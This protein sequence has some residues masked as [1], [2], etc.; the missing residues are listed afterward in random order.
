MKEETHNGRI[1]FWKFAFCLLICAFHLG[2]LFETTKIRF[3]GGSIAVEFFFLVSGFLFC[4]KMINYDGKNIYEDN[5]KYTWHSIK[6][7]A[8]YIIFLFVISVCFSKFVLNYRLL[9]FLYAF[10]SILLIPAKTPD[11]IHV[12]DIAWYISVLIVVRFALF[13][14]L[15][16]YKKKY[17]LYFAPI[18]AFLLLGYLLIEYEYVVGPWTEDVFT[19]KSVVRGFMEINIGI[20]LYEVCEKFKNIKFNKFS[21]FLLTKIETF[22]YVSIFILCN[23]T[24]PHTKYNALMIMLLF[25]SIMISF[26]GL[27]LFNDFFNKKVFFYLEKL[28]LPMYIN[29]WF[30]ILLVNYLLGLLGYNLVYY[31]TLSITFLVL[32]VVGIIE[33]F[34]I[35]LFEK[36]KSKI[37]KLFITEK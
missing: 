31:Q 24:D 26:S 8:P 22:G 11:I 34:I 32:I 20:F 35:N 4:K 6:R 13:P 15:A 18:V 10:Y 17:S 37:A 21:R 9:D 25:S 27:S 33:L 36:N 16:K 5:I 19:Y 12:Y 7:F 28:S 23:K 14:L 3:A 29:N 1:A 30:I 2:S